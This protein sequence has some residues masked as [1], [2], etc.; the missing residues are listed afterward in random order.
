LAGAKLQKGSFARFARFAPA[1]AKPASGGPA[2]RRAVGGGAGQWRS[3]MS[4]EGRRA[5]WE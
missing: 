4:V 5:A 1:F 2:R 3:L